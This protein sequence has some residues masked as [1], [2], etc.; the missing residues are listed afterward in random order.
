MHSEIW[1]LQEISKGMHVTSPSQADDF[2][3]QNH[4]EEGQKVS[5]R[6]DM[7]ILA[8]LHEAVHW[9]KL[10]LWPDAWIWHFLQYLCS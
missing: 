6:C 2:F 9:K 1:C 10:E 3:N 7:E 5:Q 8:G 4:R